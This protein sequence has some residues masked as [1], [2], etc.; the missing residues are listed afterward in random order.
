M[1][2]M[3]VLRLAH[4][5]A[6]IAAFTAA[7]TICYAFVDMTRGYAFRGRAN[8]RYHRRDAWRRTAAR[9]HAASRIRARS[10]AAFR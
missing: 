10:T 6:P 9:R 8:L 3:P 4:I 5:A 1:G 2:T 7:L